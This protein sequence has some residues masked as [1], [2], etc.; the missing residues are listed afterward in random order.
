MGKPLDDVVPVLNTLHYLKLI[1]CPDVQQG[2]GT[3]LFPQNN[4]GTWPL[5]P[6][7]VA[8]HFY[9]PD[10]ERN[11]YIDVV[12]PSGQ[13][14][15][16]PEAK[17]PKAAAYINH[18]VSAQGEFRLSDVPQ[19]YA[20]PLTDPIV[21]KANKYSTGRNGSPLFGFAAYFC[22]GAKYAGAVF[23]SLL[24]LSALNIR[25][26][27]VPVDDLEKQILGKNDGHRLVRVNV[28]WPVPA[29]FVLFLRRRTNDNGSMVLF[30]NNTPALQVH[31]NNRVMRWLWG[32]LSNFRLRKGK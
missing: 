8:G 20:E 15:T 12:A 2:Q 11:F 27:G 1:G 19:D 5:T 26:G 17:A 18:I 32:D 23:S 4:N 30:R 7:M 24:F 14:M 29:A 3:P 28:A 31:S 13:Y 10:D 6:D 16:K 21:K 9:G 25:F 22:D